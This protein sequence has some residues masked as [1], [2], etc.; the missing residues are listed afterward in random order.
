MWESSNKTLLLFIP[1]SDLSHMA[2]GQKP[3]P[4]Q[5]HLEIS[6]DTG[7]SLQLVAACITSWL[8]LTGICAVGLS[9]GWHVLSGLLDSESGC[10]SKYIPSRSSHTEQWG[11][12]WD[13]AQQSCLCVPAPALAPSSAQ[14]QAI[15]LQPEASLEFL[16]SLCGW[17]SGHH[18]DGASVCCED[19][20]VALAL[21]AGLCVALSSQVRGNTDL[22]AP[23]SRERPLA[24]LWES[25][26]DAV[27]SDF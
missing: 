1:G 5:M 22:P 6:Q 11:Y 7:E 3:F 9:T 15:F 8:D 21:Q 2:V 18:S 20:T 25:E 27:H 17:W 10:L 13:H 24:A 26:E 4:I 19:K 16:K 23:S 14:Q 12:H